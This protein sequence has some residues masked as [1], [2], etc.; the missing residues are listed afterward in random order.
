MFDIPL[1]IWRWTQRA[2]LVGCQMAVALRHLAKMLGKST[3][4]PT[5][6]AMSLR[7]CTIDY[8]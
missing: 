7:A 8:S 1:C 4:R 3:L 5:V 2:P 6:D